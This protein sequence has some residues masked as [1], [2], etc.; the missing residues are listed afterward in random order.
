MDESKTPPNPFL[1]SCRYLTLNR[2][3]LD[4]SIIQ[5]PFS[6]T[7]CQTVATLT[8]RHFLI[9]VCWAAWA[10]WAGRCGTW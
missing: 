5:Q 7:K 10:R 2:G 4:S 8:I 6:I 1:G 9:A 3:V